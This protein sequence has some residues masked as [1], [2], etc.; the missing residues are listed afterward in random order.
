[1]CAIIDYHAN[2]TWLSRAASVDEKELLAYFNEHVYY[3]L[4]MLNYAKKRI[5]NAADFMDWNAMFATFNVSARNLYDFLNNKGDSRTDVNVDAYKSHR[6]VT[7]RGSTSDVTGTLQMLNAQCF[8]M[9]QS[10]SYVPDGKV[11]REKIRE[12]HEWVVSNMADLLKSFKDDFRL[13][14]RSE[15]DALVAP[16]LILKVDSK[17][18]TTSSVFG[19]LS[20][21]TTTTSGEVYTVGVTRPPQK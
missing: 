8:H 13:K 1:M 7:K 2:L 5:E 12:M 20:T 6:T 19:T 4:L 14:L 11:N 9:G 3:E 21:G 10:R 16:E 15:W 18:L 17:S